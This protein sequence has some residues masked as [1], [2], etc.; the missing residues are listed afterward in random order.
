[1]WLEPDPKTGKKKREQIFPRYHQLE[2]VRRLLAHLGEHGAGKRYLIEH[3]AGSGKSNSIAWLAH[4][5]YRKQIAR[6]WTSWRGWCGCLAC[7]G[8]WGDGEDCGSA[9]CSFAASGTSG[10]AADCAFVTSS[11]LSDG[12]SS[13]AISCVIAGSGPRA[14]HSSGP[15]R[16]TVGDHGYGKRGAHDPLH[17]PM[18]KPTNEVS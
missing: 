10:L 4:H 14:I 13:T 17:P 9:V 6:T 5:R 18:Q 16:E 12:T 15:H 7:S 1:M 8:R 11:S 2:V 3:S